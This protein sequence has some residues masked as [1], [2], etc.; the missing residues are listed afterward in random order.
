MTQHDT[1]A[2][3]PGQSQRFWKSTVV[4]YTPYDPADS[5]LVDLAQDA[6][7]GLS[8]SP[9]ETVEEIAA[10]DLPDDAASFFNLAEGDED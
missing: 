1:Q 3:H 2:E 5:E 8:F 6:T 10:G 9:F 7:D 4:I